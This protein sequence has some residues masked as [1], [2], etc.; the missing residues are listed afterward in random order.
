[1]SRSTFFTL[2]EAAAQ[3]RLSERTLRRAIVARQLQAVYPGGR[4]RVLIP[5]DALYAFMYL[6]DVRVSAPVDPEAH[7]TNR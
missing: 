1:M 6:T 7:L 4:R 5:S 3:S 2:R